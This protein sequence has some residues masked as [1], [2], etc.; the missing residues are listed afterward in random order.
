MLKHY[1]FDGSDKIREFSHGES[2][3]V[4][5]GEQPLPEYAGAKIRY[6]QV[7]VPPEQDDDEQRIEIYMAGALLKFSDEGQ[8]EEAELLQA[9]DETISEFERETCAQL[10]M[11]AEN[12]VAETLH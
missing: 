6:L 8:L 10:A 4:A 5:R 12:I 2:T 1:V 7:Y 9:D 3:N 11:D